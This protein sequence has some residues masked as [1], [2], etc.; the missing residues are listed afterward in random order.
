MSSITSRTSLEGFIAGI[1]KSRRPSTQRK[2]ELSMGEW[3]S[4]SLC[5]VPFVLWTFA[6]MAGDNPVP[7]HKNLRVHLAAGLGRGALRS[8]RGPPFGNGMSHDFRYNRANTD[9]SPIPMEVDVMYLLA[10]RQSGLGS[11]EVCRR[12]SRKGKVYLD[13]YI[14]LPCRV[15][16]YAMLEIVRVLC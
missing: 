14:I 16:Y 12:C 2:D 7:L 5:L 1:L 10:G 11:E 13:Q 8:F 4:K 9:H 3:C 15:N 6:L